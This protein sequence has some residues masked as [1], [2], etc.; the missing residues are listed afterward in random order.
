MQKKPSQQREAQ[1]AYKLRQD[2]TEWGKIV[3]TLNVMESH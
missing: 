2:D 3:C 1:H